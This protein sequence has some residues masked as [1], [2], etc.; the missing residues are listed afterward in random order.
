MATTP[1]R[2]LR[3]PVSSNA[4]NVPVD[5]QNLATDCDNA[6]A[7]GGAITCTSSTRPATTTNGV[8]IWE[9]DTGHSL[10]YSSAAGAWRYVGD[11]VVVADATALNALSPAY[12]GLQGYRTDV[13]MTFESDGTKWFKLP[14]IPSTMF[15]IP[16]LGSTG[17]IA[18]GATNA[19]MY[20]PVAAIPAGHVPSVLRVTLDIEVIIPSWTVPCGGFVQLS[21]GPNT[22][23]GPNVIGE[24][25]RFH[26]ESATAVVSRHCEGAFYSD[27]TA[28][29]LYVL[30]S[31]DPA[32]GSNVS[33]DSACLQVVQL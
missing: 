15:S 23:G 21:W 26:G 6:L 18:P 17:Q 10:R 29:W 9:S 5:I 4:P 7:V 33:L 3:Y 32:S 2:A 27:G 1:N 20:A 31:I 19:S 13:K 30:L 28:K 11:R 12:A 8:L 16:N 24:K 14:G 25:V 22:S